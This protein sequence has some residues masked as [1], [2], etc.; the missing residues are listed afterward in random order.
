MTVTFWPAVRSMRSATAFPRAENLKASCP[1]G[2]ERDGRCFHNQT[3][4]KHRSV[5]RGLTERL[6]RSVV[7][8]K[9]G[10]FES[11]NERKSCRCPG[12]PV[13]TLGRMPDSRSAT[14]HH[15]L[16]MGASRRQAAW[17][18]GTTVIITAGSLIYIFATV[19]SRSQAIENAVRD[20]AGATV[21]N[22]VLATVTVT[23]TFVPP[24][25]LVQIPAPI[26]D[27][28]NV[29]DPLQPAVPEPVKP[30]SFCDVPGATG[31]TDSGTQM[32]CT[33]SAE[34]DRERWRNAG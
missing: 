9:P 25:A 31:V 20:A 21:T 26:A 3:V 17:V 32:V 6:A 1:V 12:H 5:G 27:A 11:T 22:T 16:C 14:V 34:D 18:I 15:T 8:A 24:S 30:G 19:P 4:S 13:D 29:P 7:A 33:T 23:E 28:A 2:Q 10:R